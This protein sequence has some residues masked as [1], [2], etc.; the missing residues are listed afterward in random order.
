MR[1]HASLALAFT[2]ALT[3]CNTVDVVGGS[4]PRATGPF[5]VFCDDAIDDVYA[6]PAPAADDEDAGATPPGALLDGQACSGPG[7]CTKCATDAPLSLHDV[8]TALHGSGNDAKTAA[9]GVSVFHV[10]FRTTRLAAGLGPASG[11]SSALVLVPD[12]VVDAHVAVVTSHRTTGFADQCAPS[13]ADPTAPGDE[14]ATVNLAIASHGYVTIAVDGAGYFYGG[15]PS[16]FLLAEDEAH[17][18]LDATRA[19]ANLFPKE[20]KP[21]RVFLVGF[22]RGGHAALSAQALAGSYGLEG[23]LAGVAAFAPIWVAPRTF[24][25]ALSGA[26]GLTI[27][28]P[29]EELAYDLLYFYGHGELYDGPGGGIAMIQDAKRADVKAAI[30]TRCFADLATEAASL[31]TKASDLFDPT[32]VHQ[33]SQ[34]AVAGGGAACHTGAAKTWNPRFSA[35]RPNVDASGA[36]IVVWQGEADTTIPPNEATCGKDALVRDLKGHEDRLTYCGDAGATHGGVVERD[37]DW[38][39]QWIDHATGH[40]PAPK[41]CPAFAPKDGMGQPVACNPIPPND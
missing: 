17:A 2:L 25:A 19:L 34:C 6:A 32:F 23:E 13:L 41:A 3:A 33:V 31:A 8:V 36:P 5:A 12:H 16:G 26:G 10:A 35:D 7:A 39:V 37:V 28:G 30:T 20:M 21:E 9:S 1:H 11:V 18:L 40:G 14:D 38:V 24:G 27:E 29:G 22:D 15:E 4:P